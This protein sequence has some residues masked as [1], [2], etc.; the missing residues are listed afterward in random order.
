MSSILL[1]YLIFT[2]SGVQSTEAD[3]CKHKYLLC[4]A[5]IASE[6]PPDETSAKTC[7][8]MVML[9]YQGGK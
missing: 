9:Q 2:C 6:R 5:V 3:E 7:S 8:V 4:L 1:S